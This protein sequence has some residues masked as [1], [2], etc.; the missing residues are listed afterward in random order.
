MDHLFYYQ[1]SEIPFTIPE[2]NRSVFRLLRL[3]VLKQRIVRISYTD[4]CGEDSS[5]EIF[6]EVIFCSGDN[7]CWYI[8]AYCYLRE[9]P[10]TFCI[11]RIQRVELTRRRDTSYGIA[12]DFREN[13]IPWQREYTPEYEEPPPQEITEEEKIRRA[14]FEL[15]YSIEHLNSERI[16]NALKN[17][18]DINSSLHG[19]TPLVTAIASGNQNIIDFLIRHGADPL[20]KSQDGMTPLIKAACS[21][22]LSILK[23]F[24]KKYSCDPNAADC[25][26]M[27]ALAWAVCDQKFD[28][29]EYLL[30]EHFDPDTRDNEGRTPLHYAAESGNIKL[31]EL[32]LEHQADIQVKNHDSET[33]LLTA[34]KMNHDDCAIKLLHR[35][36]NV[37]IAD[38][39]GNSPLHCLMMRYHPY[40]GRSLEI[41]IGSNP[42]FS[43][44]EEVCRYGANIN[45]VNNSGMTPLMLARE[46]SFRFLLKKGACAAAADIN[47]KTVAMYHANSLN[48]LEMLEKYGADLHSVDAFGCTLI[49]YAKI[50][51]EHIKALIEK[52]HFPV[53][54]K[55][56]Q[57]NTLLHDAAKAM[58]L[59]TIKY[60]L[61]L[62]AEETENRNGITPLEIFLSGERGKGDSL[63][64]YVDDP[65]MFCERHELI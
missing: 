57:G 50:S 18:A 38:K 4:S 59:D 36:A 49:H 26:R 39:K 11:D 2:V 17:G 47:Q 9:E 24:L 61:E 31:L 33:P 6:P 52:Y 54:G 56:S 55:D 32:L 12:G 19:H 16:K 29:A 28:N 53:D 45:S 8:A 3:A 23:D 15:I 34:I 5:R 30:S 40:Y 25:R 21:P 22:H 60:L 62:G 1:D 10:R 7:D 48:E 35:G 37:N 46:E 13:G 51:F 44:V 58:D 42:F 14:T 63:W 64:D 43:T 27:T 41:R 65:R 20:K